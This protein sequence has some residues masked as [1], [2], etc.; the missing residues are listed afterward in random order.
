[1]ASQDRPLPGRGFV[2]VFTTLYL[3]SQLSFFM[4][5]L[6]SMPII[7]DTMD[8]TT[9]FRSAYVAFADKFYIYAC[10]LAGTIELVEIIIASRL[11]TNRRWPALITVITMFVNLIIC[12]LTILGIYIIDLRNVYFTLQVTFLIPIISIFLSCVFLM[13]DTLDLLN[14]KYEMH[15]SNTTRAV[16]DRIIDRQ[17]K[18]QKQEKQPKPEKRP[19]PEKS[20]KQAKG[21]LRRAENPNAE[22][23]RVPRSD[24]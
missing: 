7:K 4:V 17:E 20:P 8:M 11:F 12:A 9:P 15:I 13:D 16:Q 5:T 3:L 1:M 21:T 22:L 24:D 6:T 18:R 19:K 10:L 14:G 23:V 2:I